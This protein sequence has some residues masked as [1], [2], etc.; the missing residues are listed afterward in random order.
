MHA[1]QTEVISSENRPI[2][3]CAA[4][5]LWASHMSLLP[6]LPPLPSTHSCLLLFNL[7]PRDSAALGWRP[8]SYLP[9]GNHGNAFWLFCL[10]TDPL[11]QNSFV[12]QLIAQS[13]LSSCPAA[14]CPFLAVGA[15]APAPAL[16][17]HPTAAHRNLHVLL[18]FKHLHAHCAELPKAAC[19]VA[20]Y[21]CFS[22]SQGS[23]QSHQ[24]F[25]EEPWIYSE[26][27]VG[28]L[29]ELFSLPKC[30]LSL[31]TLEWNITKPSWSL[32]YHRV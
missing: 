11:Q 5:L 25:F 19:K 15:R 28:G 27:A 12:R 3:V 2:S 17:D 10:L 31:P 26:S 1:V 29:V 24:W 16:G 6:L 23:P 7:P 30:P 14:H 4:L 8:V 32:D 21:C 20:L 13:A 9:L 18:W 22:C